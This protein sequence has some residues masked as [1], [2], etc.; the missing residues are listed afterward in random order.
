MEGRLVH[1]CEVSSTEAVQ[2]LCQGDSNDGY[3]S[4]FCTYP[5]SFPDV[6]IVLQVG[7]GNTYS[8]C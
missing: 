2:V 4:H 8:S 3:V 1:H 7:Q 6:A 5:R